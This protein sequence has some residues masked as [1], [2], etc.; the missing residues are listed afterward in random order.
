MRSI[1]VAHLIIWTT[2]L[3]M[4]TPWLMLASDAMD[5]CLV[6]HSTDTCVTTLR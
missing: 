5:K 2:F 6:K 1:I 3:F 4:L